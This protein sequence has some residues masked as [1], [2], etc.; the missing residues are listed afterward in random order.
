MG[1]PNGNPKVQARIPEDLFE[2]IES[3]RKE[4]HRTRSNFV[5]KVLAERRER[6]R[7]DDGETIPA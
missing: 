4:E 5:R 7:E 2:W 3:R 1:N 6:E